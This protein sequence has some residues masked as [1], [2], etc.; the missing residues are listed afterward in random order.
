MCPDTVVLSPHFDDAV[1]SCWHVLASAAEV[2]VVNVF[3]GE[4]AAGTL[5][6]WDRLAGATDS[7]T[8]VRTRIEEDR[9]ALALA[10][11]TAVSLPFLDSQYRQRDRASGE[12]VEALRGVVGADAR[13]YAPAALGDGHRDHR[14]VRAAALALHAEGAELE[15]YADLPHA[16]VLGWPTWVLTGGSTKFADPAGERWASQLKATGIP[17]ERMAAA[18]HRLPDEDHARK[19]AAVLAY[20]SQMAPLERVFGPL[21]GDPQLLGFEVNWRLSRARRSAAARATSASR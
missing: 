9:Q 2:L 14:A 16:A 6:W 7:A 11:C 15:L 8:A 3:G 1:L 18:A 19:L 5:G 21:L 20:R 4:P 10:D 12:I 13:L 17:G